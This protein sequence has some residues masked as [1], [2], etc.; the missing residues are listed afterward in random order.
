MTY[1][2]PSE[3]L[4]EAYQAILDGNITYEGS[5]VTVGTRIPRKT[6]KYVYLY[7][8]STDNHS[9]GDKIL[10]NITMTMQIVSIQ[11]ISEGDESVV[12]NILNQIL[13]L[14]SDADTIVMDDFICLTNQF[15]DM[16]YD[17]EMTETGYNIIKKLRMLHFIEQK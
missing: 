13:Q 8:E 2:D 3:Q 7:I 12:N 4:L 9:T 5:A 15:G 10:Y 6:T 14:V 11:D 1:K 16:E 17:T